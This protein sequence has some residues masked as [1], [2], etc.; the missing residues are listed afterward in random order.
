MISKSQ[1][2]SFLNNKRIAVIGVSRNSKQFGHVVC[3]DLINSD[4]DIYPVNPFADKINGVKAYKSLA[5][6]PNNVENLLII[7][8][9]KHTSNIVS[10][11]IKQTSIKRI[12]IQ[13]MSDTA[14]AIE[15]AKNANIDLI[16][17][18]C[19]YMFAEPVKGVHKFHRFISK[20]FGVYPK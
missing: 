13:Q 1:I 15:I 14:E 2:D 16:Y 20:L 11:A 5:Q 8:N 19:I 18:K 9:K 10:E 17:G 4:F 12:W 3:K 7:S 6:I